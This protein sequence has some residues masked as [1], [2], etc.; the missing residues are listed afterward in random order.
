M[1]YY[2][3]PMASIL[4]L[5]NEDVLTESSGKTDELPIKWDI[6]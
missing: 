3:M 5:N 2:E 6:D 4:M 1:K